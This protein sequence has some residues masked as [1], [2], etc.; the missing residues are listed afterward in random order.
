MRLPFLAVLLIALL[1]GCASLTKPESPAQALAYAD[2]QFAAAVYTAADMRAQ[3]ALTESQ[4]RAVD[5]AIQRGDRALDAAWRMLGTG[6]PDSVS[7]YVQI[8]NRALAEL[9]RHMNTAEAPPPVHEDGV[10]R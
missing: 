7:D 4:V 2:A 1:A 6:D 8:A 10:P 3:G 9:A 5:N